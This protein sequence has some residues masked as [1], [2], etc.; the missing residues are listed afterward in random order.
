[1]AK[2][3]WTYCICIFLSCP[4]Y[5]RDK[6]Q[7]YNTTYTHDLKK[8]RLKVIVNHEDHECVKQ[9]QIPITFQ[10]T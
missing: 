5:Q 10:L 2:A 9:D 1:M 3:S 6:N 8:I 7:I 4:G